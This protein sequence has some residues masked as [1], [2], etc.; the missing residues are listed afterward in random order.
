[1]MFL[2]YNK[3]NSNST[4]CFSKHVKAKRNNDQYLSNHKTQKTINAFCLNQC[5]H[6]AL[7]VICYLNKIKHCKSRAMLYLNYAKANTASILC[8]P[9]DVK[10]NEN[11]A[12]YLL[13]HVKH[14]TINAFCYKSKHSALSA[15]RYLS[16]IKHCKTRAMLF[17]KTL[18]PNNAE[19][20]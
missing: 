5:K 20:F 17:L 9:T 16:P 12:M 2:N 19:C 7:S 10:Q 4:L 11:N 3:H 14:K 8:F 13:N 1:M 15:M 18:N 6:N